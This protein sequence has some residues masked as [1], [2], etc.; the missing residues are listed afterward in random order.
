MYYI[1]E[2]DILGYTFRV[3]SDSKA[4]AISLLLKAVKVEYEKIWNKKLPKDLNETAKESINIIETNLNIVC[5]DFDQLTDSRI[6]KG[7]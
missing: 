7:E 6:Y 3:I 1:G 4:K 5:M 2:L